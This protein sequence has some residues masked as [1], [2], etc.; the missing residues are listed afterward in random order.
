LQA[1][2][3]PQDQLLIQ[4]QNQVLNITPGSS[5]QLRF[6]PVN[7]TD[8]HGMV[9][10]GLVSIK[11][12]LTG[13]TREFATQEK[14]ILSPDDIAGSLVS[15]GALAPAAGGENEDQNDSSQIS[16]ANEAGLIDRNPQSFLSAESALNQSENNV[17]GQL[18]NSQPENNNNNNNGNNNGSNGNNGDNNLTPFPVALPPLGATDMAGANHR[19]MENPLDT[20]DFYARK[21]LVMGQ[22][23]LPKRIADDLSVSPWGD[24][25][26]R[27]TARVA[28]AKG[29]SQWQVGR[30]TDGTVIV[31]SAFDIPDE[32]IRT[33]TSNQG[34]HYA[35]GT[36]PTS[37][38]PSG[39]ATYNLVAATNPT[40]IDGRAAPGQMTGVVNVIFDTAIK[41]GADLT[42]LMPD[43]SWRM[44][45]APNAIVNLPGSTYG[46]FFMTPNVTG[47][48]C[49][50]GRACSG[51]I[52]GSLVGANAEGAAL[53]YDIKSGPTTPPGQFPTFDTVIGGAGYFER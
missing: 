26:E 16:F 5:V 8:L 21:K 23:N 30:M 29:T 39:T 50:D 3:S 34:L 1:F 13:E 46:S 10:G 31:R 17:I 51:S 27:V 48:G 11:N 19:R 36:I 9:Y 28:E 22:D 43:S 24:Y 42:V 15:L 35:L 52:T 40:H 44:V 47:S 4:Y 2:L 18:N 38:P 7:D 53:V 32:K 41:I 45:Q 14:F 33:L 49:G 12:D 25:I 20:T 37:V 6:D